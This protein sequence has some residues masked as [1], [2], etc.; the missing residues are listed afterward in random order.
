MNN[1]LAGTNI[2]TVF[3]D[4]DLNILRFTPATTQI[5]NL[6]AT[7]VGR[8]V[9]HVVTNLVNYD[10]LSK[11]VKEVLDTLKSKEIEVQTKEGRWYTLR[12]NP[13]RTLENVIEGAVIIFIDIDQLV[14][15]RET[16]HK[17]NERQRLAVV[18][19]D[20]RDAITVQDLKGQILAWNLSA[21]RLYG[22]NEREALDMNVSERIPEDLKMKESEVL[23]S[24]SLSET[25]E[26]YKTKR[27]RKDGSIVEVW[28]IGTALVDEN[29]KMYGIATTERSIEA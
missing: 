20:S 16:L 2:A 5:I 4:Y 8:S 11:D 22:W 14:T 3:V 25:M 17:A 6:I 26:P 28:M 19:G 9:G 24:L 27:I 1:L 7:D 15:A 12:I 21:E 23:K 13:Y 10:S 29:G 18:V